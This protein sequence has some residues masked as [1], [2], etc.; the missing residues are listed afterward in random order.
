MS[1]VRLCRCITGVISGAQV[2]DDIALTASSSY[3]L[4][5]LVNS[6]VKGSMWVKHSGHGALR[7]RPFWKKLSGVTYLGVMKALF[8]KICA[9]LSIPVFWRP[10]FLKFVRG[11]LS[12]CVEGI[13]F[14]NLSGVIY[15]G[16]REAWFLKIC[17]GLFISVC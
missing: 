16:V 14:V 17:P 5:G 6:P 12:R 11:Y 2:V 7:P 9:G 13:V 4:E 1:A 8:F 3:I 15:P 10:C